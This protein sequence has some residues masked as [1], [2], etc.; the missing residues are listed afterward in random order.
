MKLGK[1]AIKVERLV[2]LTRALDRRYHP[3]VMRGVGFDP[4]SPGLW[5]L[6]PSGAR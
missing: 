4:G 1:I 2:P 3:F 6:D 5:R